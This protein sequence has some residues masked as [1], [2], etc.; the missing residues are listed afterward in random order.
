[1]QGLHVLG[2]YSNDFLQAG[3][4]GQIDACTMQYGVTFEQFVTDPVTGPNAQPVFQ[5]LNAQPNPGPASTSAP[6]W[7]FHK[8]LISRKGEL[9][10]HWPEPEY[11]GDDPND[12][13]DSFETSPIVVA[14]EAELAKAP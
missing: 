3:N 14:I 5:W 9:V 11:P 1:M 13:N 12:P 2:F 7:N 4:D 8:Y 6:T 10:A